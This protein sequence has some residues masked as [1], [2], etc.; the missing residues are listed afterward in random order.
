MRK[1]AC[2]L[3]L[4]AFAVPAIAVGKVTD[5][6]N[7]PGANAAAEA[8]A[9]D[10]KSD[11]KLAQK[12][13]YKAVKKTV[14]A[15][16]DDLTKST[17]VTIRAGRNSSDWQVRDRKMSINAKD[18]PL[19]ELMNSIA[20]VMKFKWEIGGKPG[21][22]SYRLFMDR[23]TLLDAEAQRVR[24]EQKIE[25][26]KARRRQDGLMQ[27]AKLGNL[28][29]AE[30]A[31]LRTENP[32]MYFIA[33]SGMGNSMG[34]FFAESP[35]A[36][37][38]ISSG[39]QFQVKG[40]ALSPAAQTGLLTTMQQ[41][42]DMESRFSGGKSNR[43]LPADLA[44]NMNTVEIRINHNME[45][46]QGFPQANM[47]LGEME[48]RYK[49]GHM[50]LP[51][52][53]PDS[54]M[55]KLIGKALLQCEETGRSMDE[56][57]KD[58]V[59]EFL[60][61]IRAETTATVGGEALIEH[62]DDPALSKKIK[63]KD[64]G[65]SLLEVE[66]AL[67]EASGYA[68]VS[69]YFGGWNMPMGETPAGEMELKEVLQKISDTFTY[70]WDKRGSVLEFRDRNWFKKRAAQIP[71]AWLEEWRQALETAGTLDIDD[72]AEIASLS[73]EQMSANFMGDGVLDHVI[74]TVYSWRELLRL[75]GS[76]NSD[77]RSLLYTQAGLPLRILSQDQWTQA[78]KLAQGRRRDSAELGRSQSLVATRK[79]ED[80]ILRYEFTLL[81]EAKSKVSSWEVTTP[82]YVAPKPAKETAPA[83]PGDA[84]KPEPK[85]ADPDKPQSAAPAEQP[86][87]AAHGKNKAEPL[88]DGPP[89][90]AEKPAEA[91]RPL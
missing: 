54:A 21:A 15:I 3:V 83:K 60:A 38:A 89:E 1:L 7:K 42:M 11:P 72:L 47:F 10:L 6:P 43:S 34:S 13:T 76:L 53:D 73:Q 87:P 62:A 82:R 39:Q 30:K 26:E 8:P 24:Q 31:K 81:D 50:E 77:Q 86:K 80:K 19:N 68:V 2:V 14:S 16:I 52:M 56:V 58:I 37:E 22:Y 64:A 33:N 61:A 45:M 36:L 46:M 12:V 40:S 35:G 25:Q 51:M 75:Y 5:D 65:R 69:D 48:F 32:F 55:T 84:A 29:P 88:D 41:M 23:K 18:V 71:E 79:E 78:Q 70:N 20:R 90:S 66:M 28:T 27:Y 63:L 49:G 91:V 57:M 85:P 9:A 4:I 59:P 44:S 17:K 67:A 74:G